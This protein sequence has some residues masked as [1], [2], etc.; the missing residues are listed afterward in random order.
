ME[1]EETER[2]KFGKCPKFDESK[3]DNNLRKQ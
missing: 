2:E 1:R 3:I